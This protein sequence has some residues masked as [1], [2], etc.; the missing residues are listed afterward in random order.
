MYTEFNDKYQYEFQYHVND[1]LLAF[2]FIRVYLLVKFALYT[3]D[4]MNP[5]SQRVCSANGCDAGPMFAVKCL[6]KQR[7]YFT[8]ILSLIVTTIV[9]GF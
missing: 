6:A 2:S 7:P 4:F 3:T 5:R 9:F 8:L 1:I